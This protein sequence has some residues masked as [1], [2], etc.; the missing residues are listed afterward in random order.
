V[1][2]L[3]RLRIVYLHIEALLAEEEVTVQALV[4]GILDLGR[5]LRDLIAGLAAFEA[6]D[7]GWVGD[8]CFGLLVLRKDLE[9]ADLVLINSMVLL[10]LEAPDEFVCSPFSRDRETDS[11]SD[12]A[13]LILL[14]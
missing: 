7:D 13:N 5:V 3:K 8:W 1:K 10:A 12:G 11:L 14:Q 6:L 9:L 4:L 2:C